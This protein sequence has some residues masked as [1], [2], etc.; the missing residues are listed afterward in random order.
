M[1]NFTS[2]STKGMRASLPNADD[3]RSRGGSARASDPPSRRRIDAAG[4]LTT[5][6]AER[7]TSDAAGVPV[8]GPEARAEGVKR[9]EGCGQSVDRVKP[10][11]SKYS[12]SNVLIDALRRSAGGGSSASL[13]AEYGSQ[14]SASNRAISNADASFE[15]LEQVTLSPASCCFGSGR[16]T[17]H[18]LGH[19][20]EVQSLL[21]SGTF[22]VVAEAVDLQTGDSVAIKAVSKESSVSKQLDREVEALRLASDHPHVT[23]LLDVAEDDDCLY[24]VQ[25][26][27]NG[28][29]LFDRLM[30]RGTYSEKAASGAFT[31]LLGALQ[32]LH[33]RGVIHRDLKPENILLA[34]PDNDEDIKLTDFGVATVLEKVKGKRAM[35]KSFMGSLLYLAP[36]I[37]LGQPYTDKVDMWSA[38][39]ILFCM[40]AAEPPLN[41]MSV[42]EYVEVVAGGEQGLETEAD[43][44]HSE[45]SWPEFGGDM[46]EDVSDNAKDLILQ[47]L[48]RDAG[49]RF[50]ASQALQH[51]WIA[52]S[53]GNRSRPLSVQ[54]AS[55]FRENMHAMRKKR[56]R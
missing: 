9:L 44:A 4:L 49:E 38:G 48:R 5:L 7:C 50:S 24:L 1:G 22:A 56:R 34:T 8:D 46:W 20:Y 23:R 6:S 53:A 35:A 15:S 14:Y 11:T 18:V 52:G 39:V 30:D 37:A 10:L 2:K 29:E 31:N 28:G 32:H 36:E 42:I 26:C 19:R 51:P 47:L 33:S 25:E 55:N 12:S 54:Y 17:P 45:A 27:A 13:S 41:V 40:L 16:T 21:G 3:P 43:R